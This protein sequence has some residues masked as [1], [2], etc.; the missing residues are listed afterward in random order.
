M[1]VVLRQGS[2]P[3]SENGKEEMVSGI[4]QTTITAALVA[5]QL[6]GRQRTLGKHGGL[7]ARNWPASQ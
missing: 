2:V 5:A 6:A 7:G 1:Y 3:S 4:D